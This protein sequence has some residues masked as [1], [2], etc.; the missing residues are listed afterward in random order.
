MISI[1]ISLLL[2]A[3]LI[4]VVNLV[5]DLLGLPPAV[6]T[7]AVIIIGVLALVYIL[8]LFGIAV[9]LAFPLTK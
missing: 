6:K 2:L 1:L 8:H 7:I 4:Y 3:L 5:I 9:P